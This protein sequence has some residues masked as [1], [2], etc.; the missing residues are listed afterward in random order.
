MC[1]KIPL[2][3]K[4]DTVESLKAEDDPHKLQ[5][6]EKPPKLLQ[7]FQDVLGEKLALRGDGLEFGKRKI[8]VHSGKRG[9]QGH[10]NRNW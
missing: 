8:S 4:S 7:R 9:R 3:E 5:A 10:L 6:A 2:K 1:H